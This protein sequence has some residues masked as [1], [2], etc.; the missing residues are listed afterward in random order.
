MQFPFLHLFLQFEV[1][2]SVVDMQCCIISCQY[3]VNSLTKLPYCDLFP[4]G[5]ACGFRLSP[6]DNVSPKG[7]TGLHSNN[8]SY[9]R[10][11]VVCHIGEIT[12]LWLCFLLLMPTIGDTRYAKFSANLH[13]VG[14]V[15]I[16][17]GIDMSPV[18]WCFRRWIQIEPGSGQWEC[19]MIA[20]SGCR[21]NDAS[22][23]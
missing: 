8:M 2:F 10:E 19:C 16:K 7:N 1:V 22:R 23:H 21:F 9:D 15:I 17:I 6:A 5:L 13:W 18:L 12:L 4:K 20:L 14:V 3:S 11:Y